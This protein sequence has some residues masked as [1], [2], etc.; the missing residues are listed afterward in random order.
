MKILKIEFRN[1]NSLKGTHEIDFSKAPFT[2]NSL[3]A[4]TGPT[5][6]GKSTILDVISLALFNRIPR[7]PGNR[8][9]SKGDIEKFGA[10]LTRNQKEAFAKITYETHTGKYTSKWEISTARTGTLRNHEMEISDLLTGTIFDLKKSEV[11]AKNEELIGLSYDQFIKA[12][13]LA[14]G[15]FA[16]LLRAEKKERGELLEKITG[17]GIYRQLGTKA[18]QKFKQVNAEIEDR[19]REIT[20]LQKDLLEAQA[21]KELQNDLTQ[22]SAACEPLQKKLDNLDRQLQLKSTIEDQIRQISLKE[23]ELQAADAKLQ[24]FETQNKEKI[25][26]HEQVQEFAEDLRSWQLLDRS[27]KELKEDLAE[28]E[29]QQQDNLQGITTCLEKIKRFLKTE[30]ATE[31]IETS[32]QEFSRKVRKLQQ[33][34]DEKLTSY[35]NLQ[36]RFHLEVR[37]VPFKLNGNLDSEEQKL[38]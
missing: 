2:V 23:N 28:K 16:L 38:K 12:V 5:G 3:F 13:L 1:I 9:L 25:K 8:T 10:V 27:C 18:F 17:T 14:Q 33:Q 19:Q 4:I 31:N 37:E 7:L 36:D 34:R 26:R 32:L 21:L 11:P 29:K 22:K 20:L 35:K 24:E 15:E 6:S 30:P